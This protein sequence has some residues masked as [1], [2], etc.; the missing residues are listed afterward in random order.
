MPRIV[1]LLVITF[2]VAVS[3]MLY[4][5][6]TDSIYQNEAL[7]LEP[8][9]VIAYFNQQP[10]LGLT[11]SAQ[12][13]SS[14]LIE[15]Q[16]ATTLLPALNMVAG[17]RMEERSPGSYRLAIRGSLI[18][19]PF[20][21][22]NVKIY[23]DEFPLTD[24][25]GNTYLNLIDPASI[26]TIHV[27]KGPDGSLYGA[28]SGGV[29]RIQPK[30]FGTP[31][32]Q[33]FLLLSGGSFGLF[34]EQFSIQR[35]VNDSYAFSIDQSFTRSD[36]YRENT[37]LNKKTF[38]TSHK[39]QYSENNELRFIALYTDL[40]YLTPGGLT[41]DQMHENPRM[42]RPSSGS[43]PSAVEQ[44][45]GIYNRTFFGGIAHNARISGRLSHTISVFGS[46]TDFENPFITNYEFRKE[47]NLG[48]RT[49]FSYRNV[50]Q[51]QFQWQMQFGFEGQKGWNR[52]D[53]YD[54][55]KGTATAPQAKDNLDNTQ[56]SF[57]YRAMAYLYNRWTIEASL[58][59]NRVEINYTQRYPEVPDPDGSA[60][61]GNIWMPRIATSYILREGLAVRGSISK[62]Y[63]PPTIAEVRS[64]DN[65]INTDLTAETGINYEL[66]IRWE[67]AGRRFIADV[68]LYNYNMDNGIVRHLRDNGAEFYLNAGEIKQKGIEAS[69][70]AYLLPMQTGRFIQ[71]LSLQS[72]VSYNH[73][74]FGNYQ[75][76]DNDFSR[77]KVTAVPDWVWTNSLFITFPKQ[78]RLNVS[79][80]FTSAMPLDDA[81]S[82]FSDKF[83]LV[84]LKG[85]WNRKMN[86]SLQIEFF[87]GIDNLLNEKY[88]LGNDIN[89]FG[90]RFFN[91]A[92]TRNYYGGT[93]LSF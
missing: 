82:F 24:A 19:S 88:S 74:R 81:N 25:G 9:E 78:F 23:V 10:I 44:E 64:S 45:S 85:S 72:A 63:S 22:R 35:K 37:A 91:P 65:I 79:H 4:G 32:N 58:G 27:L 50:D 15:T 46:H 47:K 53:N 26:S 38:Q 83:H 84:Q 60:G 33:G 13:V 77:N 36:G 29:I 7:T 71:T 2:C 21:I 42:A 11:A 6:T 54:N 5:L 39:W 61:F 69:I 62:G 31:R 80:N 56:G 76:N 8:V 93:K 12:S 70:W 1:T 40:G 52:I 51:E 67:T 49:Y 34:Q 89:A 73:Y 48:I 90:N 92:P 55:E 18:R 68:S 75:V 57:F 43:T 59:I 87:A 17:V 41:E 3:S 16:Q 20:G 86:Q 30:G 28:N 14:N 66:G